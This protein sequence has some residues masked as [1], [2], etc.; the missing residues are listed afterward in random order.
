MRE[1]TA[2]LM[3]CSSRGVESQNSEGERL[4]STIAQAS[5]S[6]QSI[7]SL[8]FFLLV[9]HRMVYLPTLPKSD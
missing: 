7:S 5:H 6:S 4:A 1:L 2:L 9:R 3:A 8:F